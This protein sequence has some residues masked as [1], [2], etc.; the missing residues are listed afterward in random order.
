MNTALS[1][2][3][4]WFGYSR[5]GAVRGVSLQVAPGDCYGFLGHNGAGKTTVMRLCLGLLQPQRGR[6]H[7]LGI[8]A[9]R[10]PRRA[11]AQVGALVERPGFHLAA[12]A[13]QNLVWLGQLQGLTRPL[14]RAAAAHAL[15]RCGLGPAGERRVGTFSLGMRQRLGIAQA[16][17]GTPRLL[18]LAWIK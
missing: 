7:L 4:L 1:V 12:T 14:A 8:D 17:L 6:V 13:R 3:D 18:L 9:Q 2:H 11:R 16:L 15:D 5:G 10:E